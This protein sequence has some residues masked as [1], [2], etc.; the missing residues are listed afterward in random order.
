MNLY[1]IAS[2][3]ILR[4]WH[5]TVVTTLAMAFAGFIMIPFYSLEIILDEIKKIKET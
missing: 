4:N 5:R 3:N 2:R 1:K